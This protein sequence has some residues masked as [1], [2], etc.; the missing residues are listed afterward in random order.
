MRIPGMKVRKM[1]P[2]ICLKP[3]ISKPRPPSP[4]KPSIASRT[5]N[6][7]RKHFL[8][9][10]SLGDIIRVVSLS[11][12]NNSQ[13]VTPN[14]KYTRDGPLSLTQ[15]LTSYFRWYRLQ[16]AFHALG[17]G[18]GVHGYKCIATLQASF[19]HLTNPAS[20]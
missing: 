12:V 13:I 1:K 8:I 20:H 15:G 11:L 4:T 6:D 16:K 19:E 5:A 10:Q 18:V 3:G 14:E 7:K 9:S 17:F 2:A